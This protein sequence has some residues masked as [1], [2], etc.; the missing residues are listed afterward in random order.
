MKKNMPECKTKLYTSNYKSLDQISLFDI[1]LI[2]ARRKNFF[3]I[4]F[5]LTIAVAIALIFLVNPVY[6]SRTVIQVGRFDKRLLEK[7]NVLVVRLEEKYGKLG[8]RELPYLEKV[9]LKSPL[10]TDIIVIIAYG[11]SRKEAKVFLSMITKE[12]IEEHKILFSDIADPQKS[13]L[14]LLKTQLGMFRKQEEFFINTSL[15]LTKDGAKMGSL[16]RIEQMLLQLG[17]LRFESKVIKLNKV[18]S[19]ARTWHTSYI[20]KPKLAKNPVKPKPA[21]YVAF[22]LI[23]GTSLGLISVL[24]TEFFVNLREKVGKLNKYTSTTNCRKGQK[25]K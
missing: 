12:I 8:R 16:L 11:H 9:T 14:N 5:S 13:H 21:F 1:W 4:P 20:L 3:L 15:N 19:K 18:L 17:I 22:G 2:F 7:P 24:L 6:M 10:A 23:L 25:V